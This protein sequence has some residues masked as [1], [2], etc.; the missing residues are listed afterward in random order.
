MILPQYKLLIFLTILFCSYPLKAQKTTIYKITG[1]EIIEDQ[2]LIDCINSNAQKNIFDIKAKLGEEFIKR[3]FFNFSILNFDIDT[4]SSKD[5]TK[6]ILA[7]EEGGQ[8]FIRDLFI[9]SVNSNDEETILN[10]FDFLKGEIFIQAELEQRIENVLVDLENSGFPF[11]KIRIKSIVLDI[12]EDSINVADIYL[13]VDKDIIRRIDEVEI[14]GNSKTNDRVI[15]NAARLT[16]GEIYSQKRIEEI[17]IQLNK[18]RFFQNISTPKYL[19]NSEGDG[20]L[21]IN[22]IEKNTNA[23]DGILGYVPANANRE[24]GYFTGFVNISLRN[25]F[26]TG[27]GLSFKWNQENSLTQ[28]L[29]LKYLE[30]WI[31]NQPFNLNLQFYQRKQ[32]SSYVKRIFGGNIEYLATENISASL[33]LESESIIP[34]INN[35]NQTVLNSTSFNSGLQL[36]IDYRDDIYSPKSGT[37]FSSTYKYRAK[38]YKESEQLPNSV[39]SNEL[40]YHNYELDFGFFYSIFSNQ[41]IALGVHAKEIIG[42][43]FD[44]SD[45]FQLGGT[46]SLRGY[47]ENQFFG[48]RIVWSNLE[49]R[50][51]L[52]QSSYIFTFYDAGYFQINENISTNVSE[53][54]SWKN[55]Y[56]LG[57]SLETTLGIM[58]V[59]YAFAEGTS[60][61]D[62]LIHFGLLNDF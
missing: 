12:D 62:G 48:N 34:S 44:L 28:E 31:L 35:S 22:I 57:I 56:G 4:T 21:Q 52:S 59:S 50:F 60:I 36:K 19:V 51:L 46:N 9:D 7:F 41:V 3:G 24:E 5:S 39:I 26:G 18:L 27:R 2:V 61:A 14:I 43:Y 23:F 6:I 15:I 38:S 13:T 10:N 40:E 33:I 42:D 11:A 54:S 25:L 53:N 8:T 49:Y 55:G 17:P 45:Y 32:D 37:Y 58:R 29:E 20:I 16:K 30:P 1:N 47:R